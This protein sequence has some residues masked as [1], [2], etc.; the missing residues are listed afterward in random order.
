MPR[1]QAEVR[2]AHAVLEGHA[3][4]SGMSPKYAAEVV[5]AMHGREMSSL[6]QH[7]GRHMPLSAMLRK[8]KRKH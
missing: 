7:A 8:K 6:P 2:L 5:G 1:S 3:T 4:D